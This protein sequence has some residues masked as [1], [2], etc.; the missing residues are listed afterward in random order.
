RRARSALCV[1][2]AL[3][4]AVVVAG[5]SG[6]SAAPARAADP[7]FAP[8]AP[9]P[10]S[11]PGVAFPAVPEAAPAAPAAPRPIPPAVTD[12]TLAPAA[13]A[14]LDAAPRLRDVAVLV[15]VIDRVAVIGGP[16]PTADHSRLAEQL[17][18][19]V[20]GIADVRNRCFVAARP[21]PLIR[22]VAGR[23]LATRSPLM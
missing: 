1:L 5:G 21:D 22:A 19:Q 17:V 10:A 4:A 13:L 15:S 9:R 7:G 11:L 2:A 14:T 8:A 18:R 3:A 6:N 16:V 12:V 20:N 23:L